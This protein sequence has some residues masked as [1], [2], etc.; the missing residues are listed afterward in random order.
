M[1]NLMTFAVDCMAMKDRNSENELENMIKESVEAEVQ[2]L[3]RHMP[4][5]TGK[6][7]ETPS[8]G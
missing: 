1:I 2:V 8:S 7:N 6:I 3:L 5:G 4:R